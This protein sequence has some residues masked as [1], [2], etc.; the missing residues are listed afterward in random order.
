MHACM[1]LDYKPTTI[2]LVFVSVLFLSAPA[3]VYLFRAFLHFTSA[4]WCF[5]MVE[6]SVSGN[7]WVPELGSREFQDVH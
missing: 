3:L 4:C 2:C 1:H 5:L 7:S 6:N